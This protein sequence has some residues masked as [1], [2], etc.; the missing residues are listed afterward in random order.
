MKAL[1][2]YI[3]M[4]VFTFLNRV[5]IFAIFMLNLNR[6]I[7]P[8]KVKQLYIRPNKKDVIESVPQNEILRKIRYTFVEFQNS[9][10]SCFKPCNSISECVHSLISAH[11]CTMRLFD[12]DYQNAF[13]CNCVTRKRFFTKEKGLNTI[14]CLKAFWELQSNDIII[15]IPYSSTKAL[16]LVVPRFLENF[17]N[18][19]SWLGYRDTS[20]DGTWRW[21][22]HSHSVFTNWDSSAKDDRGKGRDC[23]VLDSNEGKWKDASCKEEHAYLCK[24]KVDGTLSQRYTRNMHSLFQK[25]NDRIRHRQSVKR[26]HKRVRERTRNER[27][28]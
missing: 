28:L 21:T 19:E 8:S 1:D 20:L 27:V 12:Y 17:T 22:D 25:F 9:E 18:V 6:E 24:R 7:W 23:V 14:A 10:K 16:S 5:N 13:R 4:V 26:D 3:L 15:R 11:V 2:K